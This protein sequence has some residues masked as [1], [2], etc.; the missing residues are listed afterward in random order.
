MDAKKIVLTGG[1][2]T[3]KTSVIQ[4]LEKMGY[5][6]FHEVIR[7]MTQEKREKEVDSVFKTNPIVSVSDPQEFNQRILEARITQYTSANQIN[8]SVIFFDRGIPDVLGYMNCFDQKYSKTFE[9][10]CTDHTYDLV[11][12]MPPWQEIHVSDNERFESYEEALL[13]NDCLLNSYTHFG[14]GVKIVPKDTVI[15]RAEFILDSIN[16]IK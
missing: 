10:A 13:I 9:K 14:Y 1:P 15:N 5:F 4:Y 8:E 6:C 16:S 3:G 12:L 7:L 2:S 11:F